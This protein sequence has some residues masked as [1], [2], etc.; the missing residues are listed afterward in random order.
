MDR[1][2]VKNGAKYLPARWRILK[3]IK[4]IGLGIWE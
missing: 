2:G 3:H 1:G 4:D